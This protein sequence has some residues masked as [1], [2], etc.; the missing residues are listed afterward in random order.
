M[1]REGH[2]NVC[3][4]VHD[5]GGRLLLERLRRL[6]ILDKQL[7]GEYLPFRGSP[8]IDMILWHGK[9]PHIVS[10]F[11]VQLERLV[12]KRNHAANAGHSRYLTA[13]RSPIP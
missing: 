8:T 12:D 6:V 11:P 2:V 1:C 4:P 10:D 9:H 3:V 7:W 13:R 5:L